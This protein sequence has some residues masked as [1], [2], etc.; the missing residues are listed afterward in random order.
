[1]MRQTPSF[2]PG[3]A[4]APWRTPEAFAPGR[5]GLAEGEDNARFLAGVS[6]LFAGL[7]FLRLMISD[8]VMNLFVNYSGDGGSIVEKIHP[9]TQG[10]ILLLL[11]TLLKVRITLTRIEAGIVRQLMILIA[12]IV[13]L[14]ALVIASGRSM[15]MG[16][17]LET[18]IGGCLA[19]VLMYALPVERRRIIGNVIVFYIVIN[20]VLSI[21]EKAG[22]FRIYPY[23]FNE[24]TF[25][26]TAFTSHP[27]AIGLFNAGATVFVLATRWRASIKAGCLLICVMGAFASGARTGA[28]FTA[29]SVV[30]A[31]AITPMPGG[32]SESRLRQ[33]ILLFG[34]M[35]FGGTLLVG[36]AAA[37][38]FLERFEGGYVDENAQARIDVYKV[39]DWVSW[40]E[41]L[42]GADLL[43]IKAMVMERLKLLIE[44]SVVIFVFQF[45]LF[46][47]I[48]FAG[49]ILWTFW[50]LAEATDW[51]ASIALATFLATAMSNDT[52]SGKH[53]HLTTMMLLFIAFRTNRL[54][55]GRG[56]KHVPWEAR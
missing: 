7:V 9:C 36:L 20:S 37:A 24:A 1:M 15:A 56:T 47:A 28:I 55:I 34:T 19:A 27:L 6:Y 10:M 52:M 11:L 22:S 45:G 23:P 12:V 50:R 42:F 26:P 44:S 31:L 53:F 54:D 29:L 33:R 32:S 8:P 5:P 41:I 40:N 2:Q 39:F 46:G 17:L 16:Y 25:R 14:A 4:P 13:T 48:L 18:Y 35:V 21:V 30:A 3:R 51:R 38:G 43:E 49:T